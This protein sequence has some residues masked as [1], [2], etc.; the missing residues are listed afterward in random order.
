[1][2]FGRDGRGPVPIIDIT[3]FAAGQ[4]AGRK[5]VVDDVRAACEDIGFFVI[6][7]HGI[8]EAL[9]ARIYDASRAFFD[10]TAEE[11]NAIGETGPV[12]GGL[13]H[14]ALGKEALAATLG[15]SKGEGYRRS[16]RAWRFRCSE[17]KTRRQ[18]I[19][20]RWQRLTL[21]PPPQDQT[22]HE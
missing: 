20:T 7:G 3:P 9:V 6:T 10:L 2:S 19:P 11:K 21:R 1:M 12:L 18:R 5:G 13:M 4:S 8:P 17:R 14:F 22:R 16:W 15:R